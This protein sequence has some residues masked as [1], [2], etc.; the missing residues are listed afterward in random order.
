MNPVRLAQLVEER[1]RRYLETTF[2]FKDPDLRGSFQE[3]LRFGRMSKGPFLEATPVFRRGAR[4]RDLFRELLGHEP[5]VSF[6]NAVNGQRP[7]YHHQEAAIRHVAEGGNVVVATGTG[8][9][10]TEAFLYPILLDL[11]KEFQS[12]ELCPGV[13]ALV[14]YPMNALANDQRE[15]LGEITQRL[16]SE[17]SAF[18]FTFGQYIGET[19]E[20]ENDSRRHAGDQRARRLPGEL[21]LR[22]EM[23]LEPPHILL[24]NYS[25]LEYLLLRPDDSPLFDE[26]RAKWWEF[27]VLDEAHQYRGSRGIEMAMLMRRLKQRLREGGRSKPFRCIATSATLVGGEGDKPAVARF[28]SDLFGEQFDTGA[29][30]LGQVEAIPEPGTASLDRQDYECLSTALEGAVMTNDVAAAAN[31]LGVPVSQGCEIREVIGGLLQRDKRATLLRRNVIAKPQKLE[32]V[33]DETFPELPQENRIPALADLVALLIQVKEPVSGSPLLSARYHL[34]LRSLEGT[35]LSLWPEKRLLLDRSAGGDSALFEVGLCRECGQH[36]L[37]GREIRRGEWKWRDAVRDPGHPDFGATFFLPLAKE[38][39]DLADADD[40]KTKYHKLCVRC[41]EIRPAGAQLQCGH[42]VEIFVQEQES[43]KEREDQIPRCAVCGYQ[44]PDP[45]RE[46]VHGTDGPHAVI[47][48]TLHQSLP[49]GRKKVLAFADGRQQA[50][51]FAWYL[52]NSYKDILRRNLVL[53]VVQQQA[54]QSP[55]GSSLEDLA[56]GLRQIFQ[57]RNIFPPATSDLQLKREAW[58]AAYRELLTDEPR[59]SLEGVGLARWC[60]KWPPWFLVSDRLLASPWSLSPQE[61]RALVFILLDSMRTD[62]AVELRCDTAINMNWDDL[63]LQAAQLRFRI[64]EP[65]RDKTLRSW[66][67]KRGRRVQFLA[68]LLGRVGPTIAENDRI[69]LSIEAT[70]EIWDNLRCCDERAP[71][72]NDRLLIAVDDARRLNPDW[73]RIQSI[74]ESDSVFQCDTCGRLQAVSVRAVCPRPRCPG[75]LG[76]IPWQALESNHYRLLYESALPGSLRVEEHTAQLDKEKAREFQREFREDK[77]HVLSCSTTFELGVDLGNLDTIF[78]RNV[79]PEA[80][81][82]AQRVGRAGRRSGHPGFA[83]TYCRRGPHDLYHFSEPDRILTGRVQPP[84]LSLRNEKIVVRHVVAVAL[85]FFFRA[86]RAR[87]QNVQGLF[88]ELSL[89]RGVRDFKGFLCQNRAEIETTIQRIAPPEILTQLGLPDGTWVEKV[90]GQ[91]SRFALAEAEVSSDHETVASLEESAR[92]SRDYRT[93]EWA[94]KRAETIAQEEV[95]TFLSRKAVIPKYG[96]PVDVVELDTQRT[97]QDQ[98]AFEV[99]LQRDL[100]IAVSEFAPTSKL[101]ANKKEWTSYGLKKVAERE[102]ERKRYTR[103]PTHNVF[104][105]W[106][107][108]E[109]EPPAMPCGDRLQ[110]RKYVIPHF[111]FVTGRDKPKDPKGRPPRVF[112]TRPYF[113]RPLGSAPEVV[114][115][116]PASPLVNVRK[117][118]PGLMVVLCEGRRGD[119]FYLCGACGAGFRKRE[120]K[121]RTPQGQECNGTLDQVSLGHEFVTDVL[122]LQFCS[123]PRSSLDRVWFTFSLAYAL[124]EGAAEVLEVPS[125]DLSTTVAHSDQLALPPIILY[126]NVPGGAGLVARLESEKTLKECLEAALKRVGGNCGCAESTSCYGCLRSYRNQFAHDRLERGPVR[127]YLGSILS[128]CR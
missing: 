108:G 103:C 106:K 28:A 46:V 34:F 12:G 113:A 44:A 19:P 121:H 75:S 40:Y 95:L 79:P 74:T 32:T 101:V 8:S 58:L 104:L 122:Q 43:A 64:G 111:G 97:R 45:V 57:D 59:I 2:Y 76:G 22:S 115:L 84:V 128:A 61:A 80:F 13:R 105:E 92:N 63:G 47:A 78:L 116:P 39:S 118:S 52:E 83:I 96:F 50:A 54:A 3:N 53:R 60:L 99:S 10:K 31:K 42:G 119:G 112:S 124:A 48:T 117:A 1:Y 18:R 36:Y 90:A 73:W 94:R 29:V 15:R 68:K 93:A 33:A 14:L 24:T 85:S 25:M 110:P 91:D 55:L 114:T 11:Y 30:L 16:A 27:L 126:D 87:F 35:F 100:T 49:E 66:D 120:L 88:G 7:L 81:N 86:F 41:G 125:I 107:E 38:P 23:R 9:G 6:L 123:A 82:Y 98:E 51:F 102:W 5:E 127:E 62:R 37:V 109:A 67:G 26:G 77:I 56:T 20:N 17:N 89:P 21:V 4:P 72:P 65:K 70:R 71:T 69:R